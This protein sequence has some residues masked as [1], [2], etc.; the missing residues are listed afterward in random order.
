MKAG[1]PV[2]R[3]SHNAMGSPC[4]VII[5]GEEADY[6]AQ[7]ARAAF[8]ELDRLEQELSRFIAY[9]DISQINALEAGRSV[10]VGLAALECLTLAQEVWR[11]T[12][13][14]FDATVGAL[15]NVRRTPDGR[16]REPGPEE[17]AD[18]LS[19]TG[20]DLL[21]ID[22]AG[23][24]VGVRKTGVRIDLGA[25]GKGYAA[26][27][28]VSVLRE[29]GIGA[30]MVHTG[31][32]SVYALGAPAGEKGWGVALRNPDGRGE[33]LGHVVL[34]GRAF[35]GSGTP[36]AG[37]H[38]LDPR[39]GL[40]VEG[41]VGTWVAAPTAATSDALSTAFMVMNVEEVDQYCRTHP[42]VSGILGVRNPDGPAVLYFG[43]KL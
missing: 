20:M 1:P 23:H 6:A 35:S 34:R 31:L 24:S 16:C 3:F 40:F 43:E 18:A 15:M 32:S 8:A 29:Y 22:A 9:S 14:A 5:L 41:R 25:V 7:A 10:L 17:L 12:G 27:Q 37:R 38:I 13:G 21:D 28:M 26:D 19:R 36:P 2:H 33:P 39:T 4:E 30:A 11:D 42:G